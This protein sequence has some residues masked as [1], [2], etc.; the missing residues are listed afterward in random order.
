MNSKTIRGC[1][2]S[3]HLAQHAK[4]SEETDEQDNPLLALFYIDSQILPLA[5]KSLV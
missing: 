3:L 5:K 4:A 1:D 2:L